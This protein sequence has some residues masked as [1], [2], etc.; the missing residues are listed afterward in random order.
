MGR[1]REETKGRDRRRDGGE[2]EEKIQK[3]DRRTNIQRG[4]R[5]EEKE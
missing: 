2:T 4:K 5:S 3:R 1:L